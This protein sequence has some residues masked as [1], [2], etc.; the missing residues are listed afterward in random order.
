MRRR[1][2]LLC[3]SLAAA[4]LL[5]VGAA[6]AQERS[7]ERGEQTP[8]TRPEAKTEKP[9]ATSKEPV[10]Q[11]PSSRTN[12]AAPGASQGGRGVATGRAGGAS[13]AG[14]A[15]LKQ[16]N[17]RTLSASANIALPQDI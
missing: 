6:D 3:L 11:A 15:P 13:T 14:N 4:G 2:T 9:D 12:V 5:A 8:Q 16:I 7:Q 1:A 10:S 17:T